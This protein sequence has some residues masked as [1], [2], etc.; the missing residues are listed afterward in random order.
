MTANRSSRYHFAFFADYD[1]HFN[2]TTGVSGTSNCWITRGGHL[3][4]SPGFEAG[5]DV[6]R[7]LS[8]FFRYARTDNRFTT[9]GRIGAERLSELTGGLM[10]DIS[11]DVRINRHIAESDVAI[12]VG[13]VFPHEVVGFSG[14]NKYFF[15]GVSGQELIDLSLRRRV[16]QRHAHAA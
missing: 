12:V 14:G 7:V 16:V 2:N 6:S 4:H 11:V 10:R 1:A 3:K 9:L 5:S 13:P 15:P 8:A